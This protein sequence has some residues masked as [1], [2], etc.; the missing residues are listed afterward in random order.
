MP[1]TSPSDLPLRLV[2]L[3]LAKTMPCCCDLDRWEPEWRT[4]HS[5]VCPIHK[6]VIRKER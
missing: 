1:V 5:W 4:G 6:A 3:E 2:A